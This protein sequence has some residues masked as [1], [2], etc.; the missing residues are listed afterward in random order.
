MCPAR[1]TRPPVVAFIPDVNL[2]WQLE[3]VLYGDGGQAGKVAGP[4]DTYRTLL[5]EVAQALKMLSL[6]RQICS[7]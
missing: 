7:A 3:A 5:D 6:R 4:T 2:Q 1:K